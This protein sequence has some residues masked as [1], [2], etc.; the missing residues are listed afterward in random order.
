MMT[1][2]IALATLGW[3]LMSSLAYGAW[4]GRSLDDCAREAA[5]FACMSWLLLTVGV[6][7]LRSVA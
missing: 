3:L 5:G 2:L 7:L 4:T 6:M 1:A